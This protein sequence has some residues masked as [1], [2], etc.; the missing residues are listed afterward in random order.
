MIADRTC[1]IGMI[2]LAGVTGADIKKNPEYFKSLLQENLVL[3]FRRIGLS[4]SDFEEILVGMGF[5]DSPLSHNVDHATRFEQIEKDSKLAEAELFLSW[6]VEHPFKEHPA[7]V[8]AMNMHTFKVGQDKGMT[9][10]VDMHG[11]YTSFPDKWKEGLKDA[12]TI[13][14]QVAQFVSP[15]IHFPI[16]LIKEDGLTGELIL[17]MQG[18]KETSQPPYRINVE[19]CSGLTEDDLVEINAWTQDY[20]HAKANQEWWSW[21]QGDMVMFGGMR[22]AHAVTWGF[23]LGQRVFDRVVYHGGY[24]DAHK[25]PLMDP[26]NR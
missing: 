20:I 9:G 17:H 23:E 18:Y 3:G 16:K 11:A 24:K 1:G 15:L 19:T 12:R 5:D 4:R 14:E 6:H 8:I 10:F 26:T 2:E 7:I 25:V 21:E 13:E 22:M